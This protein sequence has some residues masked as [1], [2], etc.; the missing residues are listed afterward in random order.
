MVVEKDVRSSY[1]QLEQWNSVSNCE[2]SLVALENM[3]H[4]GSAV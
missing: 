1:D 2:N 3:Q 4:N